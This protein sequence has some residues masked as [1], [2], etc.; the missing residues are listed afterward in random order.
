MSWLHWINLNKFPV[1]G[2]VSNS[3]FTYDFRVEGLRFSL[4]SQQCTAKNDIP[5]HPLQSF[6]NRISRCCRHTE[7]E[8]ANLPLLLSCLPSL[9]IKLRLYLPLKPKPDHNQ[10]LIFSSSNLHPIYSTFCKRSM[11]VSTDENST[12]LHPKSKRYALFLAARDSDYVKKVYG[13]YFNVFVSAFEEEGETWDFF[14]VVDEEFPE[15][16]ELDKYDGFVVSG[17]PYDAYSDESWIVKLCLILK[18][19]YIME[20]KVL[21]ICF[22]HQVSSSLLLLSTFF[23]FYRQ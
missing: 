11:T 8:F 9:F 19:L 1:F 20:K 21:G 17:S 5:K 18:T 14:R 16:T 10:T 22:G 13:G 7:H 15:M 2:R 3:S 23:S 6:K 4:S 12:I